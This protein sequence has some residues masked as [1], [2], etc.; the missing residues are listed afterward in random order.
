MGVLVANTITKSGS[1]VSGNFVHIVVVKVNA[2]YAPDPSHAGT[3]TIIA[4]Y[5]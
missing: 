4:T 5:C 2:G 3:G 1:T